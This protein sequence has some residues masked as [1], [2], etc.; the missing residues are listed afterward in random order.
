MSHKLTAV[1]VLAMLS[2]DLN[3]PV[4]MAAAAK[5]NRILL[6]WGSRSLMRRRDL[7]RGVVEGAPYGRVCPHAYAWRF[8]MSVWVTIMS[9]KLTA[10]AVLAMLSDDLN[11]P[12]NMAAAAKFNRILLDLGIK[13]ANAKERFAEGGR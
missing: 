2:D 8:R 10:V 11:Q 7:L 6:D 5:F 1:A 3:Q 13:V 9:H 4:D 12:V